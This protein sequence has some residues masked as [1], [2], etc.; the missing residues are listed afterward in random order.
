MLSAKDGGT[1]YQAYLVRVP[2]D[3][4]AALRPQ[5]RPRWPGGTRLLSSILSLLVIAAVIHEIRGVNV[6]A[7]ISLIPASPIFWAV[8]ALSY[9]AQ[10][11]TEWLIFRRLWGVGPPAF[12]ALI[13]KLIYNELLLGY[14]GEVYFY[15]WARRKLNLEAAPFGAVKDVTILSAVAGNIVTLLM[16][17]VAWPLASATQLGLQSRA[18]VLSLTVVLLTSMAMLLWRRQIFS[19]PRPDLRFIF[20]MHIIRLIAVT[21]LSAFLWHLILP[22]IPVVWWLLLATIRLLISRL[23][24][25]PNKD[26]VFA[27]LAVF[28]LGHDVEIASLL[29]LMAGLILLSHLMVGSTFALTDLIRKESAE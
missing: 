13:R 16:L 29:T 9:F 12:A 1:V 5:D 4:T 27:G 24:F 15:A 22:S 26:V 11:I 28:M 7:I 25:V 14:L 6:R 10:P 23:P 17:M 8:F 20:A 2:E 3:M 19:L 21:G 18:V